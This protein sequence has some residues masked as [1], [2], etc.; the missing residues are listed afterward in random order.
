MRELR[1]G[2]FFLALSVLIVWES[3]RVELGTLKEPGSGFLSLCAGL[4]VGALSLVLIYRGWRVREP[5]K[6]HSHRVTFALV[7]LFIYSLVLD[8]LGFVVATFFLVGILFRLGQPRPWWF[9]IGVSALVTFLSYLIFGVF[10]RVYF[11]RGF[12]GI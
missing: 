10:L 4:G 2:I 8:S 3:F 9:L 11:P 5:G 6:P 12:L 7:S 1:G